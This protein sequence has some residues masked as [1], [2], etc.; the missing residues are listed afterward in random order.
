MAS[1]A[2]TGTLSRAFFIMK[3]EV[4]QIR[5]AAKSMGFASFFITAGDM[6]S[7]LRFANSPLL[8]YAE[9]KGVVLCRY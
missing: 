4:P 7:Q 3:N 5:A 9:K 6:D 2:K 8:C 1:R